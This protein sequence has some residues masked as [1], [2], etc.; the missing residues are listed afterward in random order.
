MVSRITRIA[1]PAAALLIA[2]LT[3]SRA[4]AKECTTDAECGA[5]FECMKPEAVPACPP[6]TNCPPTE[7]VPDI[8]WCEPKPISCTTDA[9]CPDFMRCL[10][11]ETVCWANSDG[12]SGCAEPD[13]SKR[14]CHA[15]AIQCATSSDCPASFE[16]TAQPVP[17]PMYDCAPGTDCGPTNCEGTQNVCTPKLITCAT[18]AECP[19]AW[20][21]EQTGGECA[22]PSGMGGSGG[23]DT[24]SPAV[25]ACVP[26]GFS[27]GTPQKAGAAEDSSGSSTKGGCSMSAPASPLSGGAFGLLAS[28]ALLALGARRRR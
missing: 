11:Q 13:P 28:A 17:C 21:C 3:P 19:S 5:G 4:W 26:T 20:S 16:C 15:V 10:D 9:E 22:A 27:T 1:L 7:P 2:G 8:G 14:T 25:L 24:C 6:D 18:N 23:S 12:T